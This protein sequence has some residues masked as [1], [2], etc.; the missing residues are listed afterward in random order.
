MFLKA[1]VLT[2]ALVAI[3]GKWTQLFSRCCVREAAWKG[4]SRTRGQLRG[5]L[6][7]P[8]CSYKN[9]LLLAPGLS[10]LT[11]RW[12]NGLG[13]PNSGIIQLRAEARVQK[14]DVRCS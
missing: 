14:R 10:G 3:T 8:S 11:Q 1:V 13:Y 2:L 5:A 4:S 9:R 7:L 12:R 6:G